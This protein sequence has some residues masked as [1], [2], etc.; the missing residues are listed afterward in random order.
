LAI[1]ESNGSSMWMESF[2]LGKWT[3]IRQQ[4]SAFI[5]FKDCLDCR[6][7]SVSGQSLVACDL[8][9]NKTCTWF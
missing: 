1:P 2:V 4:V 3:N 6:I 5:P 9:V 8:T 7:G